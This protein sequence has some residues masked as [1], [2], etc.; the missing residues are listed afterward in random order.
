MKLWPA[1]RRSLRAVG[2]ALIPA[3]AIVQASSVAFWLML[4]LYQEETLPQPVFVVW[5]RFKNVAAFALGKRDAWGLNNAPMHRDP[6]DY[7]HITC[8]NFLPFLLRRVGEAPAWAC[9]L[10]LT[11]W[12]AAIALLAIVLWKL[13]RVLARDCA[14]NQDSRTGG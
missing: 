9:N 6:W 2:A 11:L 10:T 13:W 4:E 3:S 1:L 12:W 5:L 8:W 7:V 14:V